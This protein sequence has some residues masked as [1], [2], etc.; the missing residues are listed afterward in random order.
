MYSLKGNQRESWLKL[1][2][3]RHNRN[4]NML[5]GENNKNKK[6]L[7]SQVISAIRTMIIIPEKEQVL[8]V[9]GQFI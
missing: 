4:K 7:N 1:T 8:Q 2:P 5:I 6:K 3:R 9:M